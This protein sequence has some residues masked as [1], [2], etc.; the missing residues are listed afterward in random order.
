MQLRDL[1][2]YKNQLMQDILTNE[3][4][5]KMIDRTVPFEQSEKLAYKNVFPYEYIPDT[6]N[7]GVTYVCFD[8]DVLDVVSKTFLNPTIYV[9]IFTHRT[10]MRLP[11]G[12]LLIDEFCAELCETINGS[13]FYGMGEL[14]LVSVRRFAPM[15]DFQ[16]KVL[17]FRATEV[18]R[19]HLPQ[20]PI[21]SN[22]KL[23]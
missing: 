17:A 9:W 8:V 7:H 5:V 18:N 20:K 6:A 21:P 1:F 11:E 12:G 2:D 16:G 22:R 15:T 14:N 3:N 23:G 4:L 13:R 10:N 19:Y